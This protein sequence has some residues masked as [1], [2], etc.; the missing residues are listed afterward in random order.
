[1]PRGEVSPNSKARDGARNCD[2]RELI[3]ESTEIDY[4]TVVLRPGP[5]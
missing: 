1:M 5:W 2:G 3:G 4:L